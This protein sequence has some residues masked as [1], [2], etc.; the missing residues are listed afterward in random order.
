MGLLRG[1]KFGTETY[2]TLFKRLCRL[3]VCISGSVTLNLKCTYI[4]YDTCLLI[5]LISQI[6]YFVDI[7][8][9]SYAGLHCTEVNGRSKSVGYEPGMKFEG[10]MFRNTWNA[11]LINGEWRLV[12]CNWGARLVLIQ[13]FLNLGQPSNS[14][15]MD[16][17]SEYFVLM[18]WL[19]YVTS[20]N[21]ITRSSGYSCILIFLHR[22]ARHHYYHF[23]KLQ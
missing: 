12:Q 19:R 3:V 15:S 2:H 1:I 11:V 6:Q 4:I 10:N 22:A 7:L 5:M 13:F 9:C 23:I 14:I 20:H 18:H 17:F 16:N 21:K 8:F